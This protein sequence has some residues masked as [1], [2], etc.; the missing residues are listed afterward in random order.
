MR[1]FYGVKLFCKKVI[2][3]FKIEHFCR[4]V[5]CFLRNPYKMTYHIEPDR[6]LMNDPNGLI[7][8][9]G[10]YYFFHQ[11]NRFDMNHHYKEWGLFTSTNMIDWTNQGS[12]IL[13][14]RKLDRNGV[15]SGSSIE[16]NGEMYLFY[17]GNVKKNGERKS[18]QCIS[19]SKNGRTFI[20]EESVIETPAEF[21][22]HHRDP[23]V[24]RG[25]NN[26]WMVVGAQTKERKGA[27]A[28]YSSCDLLHW[29][30]ENIL[31]DQQLDNMCECPD[32]FSINGETDIL[33]CCPQV[34]PEIDD[35]LT[36]VSSYAAF[37]SGKFDEKTKKFLPKGSLELLDYGF[38]FYAPQSFS[39][40]KGRRILVGWMSRM[41]EIEEYLCP[42]KQYGYLHCLTLP[43]VVTLKNGK[44]QQLPI[45]EVKQ[46]RKRKQK[47]T[48]SQGRFE[49]ESGRFELELSRKDCS[50]D[51]HLFLRD[52]SV[53]IHYYGKK[54]VLSVTRVNWVA[55]KKETKV[56]QV[57]SL[58]QMSIF[59]DNSSIEIFVNDGECVFSLR[60]FTEEE[61]LSVKYAGLQQEG[62]LLYFA[63]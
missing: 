16:H 15:Y 57:Q 19:T 24:W 38:D 59:S 51:F 10:K 48:S 58:S 46:L 11:W 37:I 61:N 52:C 34:R 63:F 14:D 3:E 55:N 36:G 6:G 23:K 60:Y 20:K 35:D 45:E 41:S 2:K 49:L 47:F 9:K 30:Y 43:R 5:G 44:I 33:L 39:D 42:T 21:T 13:P 62:E 22:E 27:I 26:W 40:H 56:K 12:A 29:K 18:Y 54:N 31:Y 17:T 8:F 50:S 32:L 53:E 7:W 25:E 1:F 28:L 4:R